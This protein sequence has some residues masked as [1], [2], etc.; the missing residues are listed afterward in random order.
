MFV[1][2]FLM[3]SSRQLPFVIFKDRCHAS[4]P[5]SIFR[6]RSWYTF[7]EI[8]C[9][10]KGS[11]DFSVVVGVVVVVVVVVVEVE[12]EVVV[13]VVV[14]VVVAKASFYPPPH[15]RLVNLPLPLRPY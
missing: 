7:C 9:T 15:Q 6:P 11:S 10:K 1:C 14:V 5:C 2:F 8:P 4:I 3:S 13:V 12:V